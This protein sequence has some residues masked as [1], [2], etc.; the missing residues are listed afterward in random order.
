MDHGVAALDRAPDG[1]RVG[2][3]AGDR[4]DLVGRVVG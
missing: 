4:V 2:Q 3:V 1:V